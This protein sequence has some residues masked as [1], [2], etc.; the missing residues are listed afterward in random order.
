M[1]E[2]TIEQKAK[3]YDELLVKAKQI[4]N[5]ENDVLIMYTI[6]DLFPELKESEGEKVRKALIDFFGKSAKYGGQTNGVYDKNI[7]AWLEKQTEQK[8]AWGEE[9]ERKRKLII[10]LLEGWLST[11]KE[12][13]YAEDCKCGIDWLKSLKERITYKPSEEQIHAFE[14]VYEWY[15]NNFAPSETLTSLYNDL[16]KFEYRKKII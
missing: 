5:K 16:K 15:N 13:C 2:L 4:Y 1:K 11:F 6:E 7:L 3:A 14:Q 12:T 9:D 8:L 10:G